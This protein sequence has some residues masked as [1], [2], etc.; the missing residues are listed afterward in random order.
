MSTAL[1]RALAGHKVE[2]TAAVSGLK[3]AAEKLKSLKGRFATA[4][5][6]TAATATA[7]L[8]A[9]ETIGTAFLA[10]IPEGYWGREKLKVAGVP[11]RAVVGLGLGGWGLMS[12]LSG[13]GGGHQLAIGTGVLSAESASLGVVAGQAMREKM[14]KDS[15]PANAPAAQPAPQ[16]Q[17]AP[18]AA[19][20][21]GIAADDVGALARTIRMTPGTEGERTP[22]RA[23][24]GWVNARAA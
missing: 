15:A 24:G 3:Q 10:S 21:R 23:R 7:G 18:A 14:Q 5:E 16:A 9:G 2:G 13:H 8:H 11:V 19:A 12:S 6:N 20:V 17:P 22:R 1:D 4:K